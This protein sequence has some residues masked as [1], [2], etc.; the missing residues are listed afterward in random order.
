MDPTIHGGLLQDPLSLDL[1]LLQL[2]LLLWKLS[3][4]SLV[5][6]KD[7]SKQL[8]YFLSGRTSAESERVMAETIS[9]D[10]DQVPS[11]AGPALARLLLIV[12]NNS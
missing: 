1:H 3:Q 2:Q 7:S 6:Q 5:T 12:V 10:Q 9:G 4:G 8:M 11:A